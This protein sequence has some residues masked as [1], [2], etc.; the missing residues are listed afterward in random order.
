MQ[1]KAVFQPGASLRDVGFYYLPQNVAPVVDDIV[2]ELHARVVPGINQE[3]QITPVQITFPADSTDGVV[4]DLQSSTPT[5]MALR[6]PDWATARW[7]AHDDNGDHL[8]YSVYY[9]GDDEANWQLLKK[10][11]RT[12]Y[13]SFDLRRIPDGHYTL[14]VVASDAPSHLAGNALTGFMDSDHFLL[15]TMPPVVSPLRATLGSSP[16]AAIHVTFDAQDKFSTI[17]RAYYSV[18]AGPWQ[19]VEPVGQLSDSSQE[20]Y[21]FTVPVP[22]P[23]ASTD[24]PAAVQPTDPQQH[25]LAVRVLNRAGNVATAKAIVQ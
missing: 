5:L 25:I 21:D 7:K 11:L 12:T 2:V 15:D 9:R 10:D 24:T 3:A 14:R 17:E 16:A 13:L 19:Y 8:S 22:K 1:W 6:T 20:H 18:D 23:D 4:Y